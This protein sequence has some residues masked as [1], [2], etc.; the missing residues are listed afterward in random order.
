MELCR[1]FKYESIEQYQ[2]VY[3]QGQAS[4]GKYYV[5]LSGEV[6]ETVAEKS[7]GNFGDDPNSVG[8]NKLRKGPKI[9]IHSVPRDSGSK[10][11][12]LM[13]S[14]SKKAVSFANII[15]SQEKRPTTSPFQ[16]L[17]VREFDTTSPRTPELFNKTRKSP[18][19]INSR[20]SSTT[21]KRRGSSSNQSSGMQKMRAVV[22]AV[23]A[24]RGMQKALESRLNNL[25]TDE[26]LEIDAGTLQY[27]DQEMESESEDE[28]LDEE[29]KKEFEEYAKKYGQ[30]MRYVGKG[31]GFG[32]QG[33]KKNTPR[34]A[35]MICRANC[36]F[37]VLE[38]QQYDVVFGRV[39]R[40]KEEFLRTVFP[41]LDLNSMSTANFNYLM[42]SFKV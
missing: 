26:C 19:E 28:I 5:I 21:K 24:V 15:S 41:N 32:E 6:A 36:E 27:L 16:L 18:E 42:C 33:L 20:K 39:Q 40:E 7:L 12:A 34:S 11:E 1:N 13:N 2:P 25:K 10:A 37:L 14:D 17:S 8:A 9:V 30:L 38:K 31:E 35:S 22:R 3:L 29:D 23:T 4:N